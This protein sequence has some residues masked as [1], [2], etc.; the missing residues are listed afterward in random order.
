[1]KKLEGGEIFMKFL[2]GR[3]WRIFLIVLP[4][5]MITGYIIGQEMA[6]TIE[7]EAAV[8]PKPVIFYT[9]DK[10][11]PLEIP[12]DYIIDDALLWDI[13]QNVIKNIFVIPEMYL[14]KPVIVPF[15]DLREKYIEIKPTVTV[16]KVGGKARRWRCVI[17]DTKGILLRK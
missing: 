15:I 13:E 14:R 4:M 2:K 3:G 8:E 10:Y 1:M 7:A 11:Q 16:Y 9:F 17:F 6:E 5:L 12:D